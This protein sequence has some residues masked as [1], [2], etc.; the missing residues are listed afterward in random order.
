MAFLTF[1]CVFLLFMSI[2][3]T[4]AIQLINFDVQQSDSKD[5]FT[6]Q[7]KYLDSIDLLSK[8]KIMERKEKSW[9]GYAAAVAAVFAKGVLKEIPPEKTKQVQQQGQ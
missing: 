3:L 4:H 1:L 5:E 7:F 2:Q 8:M 9:Q 6:L